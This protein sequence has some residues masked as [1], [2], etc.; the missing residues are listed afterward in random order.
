MEIVDLVASGTIRTYTGKDFHVFMPTEDQ[1]DIIDIAHALSQLCRWGGHCN[2]FY[3][4]AQHSII[5]AR[6]IEYSDDDP[7]TKMR[8]AFC[9]LLHDATE[10]YLVDLPR[11][12][13][14]QIQQYKDTE[15]H[16][17]TKIAAKYNLPDPM[18]ESVHTVD[19]DML[20]Y[21]WDYF[22]LNEPKK[23]DQHF[24]DAY[25]D[26]KSCKEIEIEFLQTFEYYVNKLKEM[27]EN[28]LT[29]K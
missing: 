21:E 6:L 14:R 7:K 29:I 22:M 9:A 28:L 27:E 16:L 5:A 15:N 4:V 23:E 18:P 8:D 2:K 11:P 17:Y 19:D 3:S 20:Y 1:I 12:I 24:Y 26:E 10:A 13:K 25:F